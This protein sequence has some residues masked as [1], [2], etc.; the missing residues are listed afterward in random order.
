MDKALNRDPLDEVNK[1]L[2]GGGMVLWYPEGTRAGE[3]EKIGTLKA[4][5]SFV[6]QRNPLCVS[7]RRN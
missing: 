5:I 4:G 3:P 7:A 1:W 2:A 6:L